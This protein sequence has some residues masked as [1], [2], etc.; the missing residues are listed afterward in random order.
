MADAPWLTIVGLGEDGPDGLTPASLKALDQ[1]KTIVGPARHL[2]LL[3]DLNAKI[4]EWPV[5]FSDGLAILDQLRGT[6]TVVLA[7]GDPFW[8]GAGSVIAR[9][10]RPG[11]WRALPNL[12]VFAQAAA[13]LGWPLETTQCV[14]LHAAPFARLYPHLAVGQRAIATVRDGAAVADFAAWL[15]G[16]GF[17]A[18]TLH[19]LEALGGPNERVRA[20]VAN[21]FDITDI[22]HPVAVAIEVDG[23]G[24]PI[25]V[26]SGKPDTLF[27]NDGQITK[28]PIRAL[29]LSALAPAPNEMLWDLGAGSG[30]VAIEW[31]MSHPGTQAVAVETRADRAQAIHTNANALGQDRLQIVTGNSLDHL[32]KLPRPDA[33][34]VG[35]G[36]S[37]DLIDALWAICPPGTRIVANA[38]TLETEALVVSAQARLGGDLLRVALSQPTAIGRFRAWDA[39]YPL[40]QWSVKR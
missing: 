34:F 21:A 39:A 36:L 31:L 26:S 13:K 20:L 3:P 9:H 28:R 32:S 12:S 7:S 35:G 30:S 18:S 24:A 1:A 15:D 17:G 23:T 10:L 40:V 19:V 38:V 37:S 5:P 4:I 25:P 11:E 6:P 14:G 8:F 22:G 2:G 33:V 29:T 16:L 27:E